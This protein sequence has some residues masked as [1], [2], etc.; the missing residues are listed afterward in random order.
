MSVIVTLLGILAAFGAWLLRG[1]AVNETEG[2]WDFPQQ[3][4]RDPV[5][6]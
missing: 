3:D 1:S 4:D 2:F 5:P 6:F